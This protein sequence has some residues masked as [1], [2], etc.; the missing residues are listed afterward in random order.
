MV[1]KMKDNDRIDLDRKV[2]SSLLVL[3][4]VD[5]ALDRRL[6]EPGDGWA[7]FRELTR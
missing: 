6:E 1:T 5:N 3:D 2:C 4:S 7:V